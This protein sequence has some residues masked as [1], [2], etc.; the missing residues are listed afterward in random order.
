MVRS[1]GIL[2]F[3][4]TPDLEVLIA[5]PGGPFWASRNEGAWGVVK[6]LV[7]DGESDLAAA[8]REFEEET[9][10]RVPDGAVIPLGEVVM[11]SGK[12]VVTWAIEADFD[13]ETLA[14]GTFTTTIGGR[15]VEFPEIDRV[16]WCGLERA[17]E[18]MILAQQELLTRLVSTLGDE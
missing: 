4:R 5:H 8:R 17:G 7:E 12:R 1:A 3:R 11:K 2:P 6:G 10:W 16:E 9:G 15:E 13:P 14:P 18:L